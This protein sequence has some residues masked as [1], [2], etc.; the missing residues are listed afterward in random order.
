MNKIALH[1]RLEKIAD[2]EAFREATKEELRVL[3]AAISL[4]KRETSYEDL[5]LLAGVSSARAKSA[6]TLFLESGILSCADEYADV[7]DEFD[8]PE[9]LD[10]SVSAAKEIRD[11]S[12]AELID[13]CAA[14]IGVPALPTDDVK[15]ITS[16]YSDEGIPCENI[17]IITA[18]LASKV[19]EG[20]RLTSRRIVSE[21]VKLRERGI[22]T[23]EA[24][25]A[26]Y[27]EKDKE[28]KDE[29][30][31]RRVL[32]LSGKI[33]D[34][35]RE[36]IDKWA[37]VYEYSTAIVAFAFEITRLNTTKTSILYM[38]KLLTAWHG[39]G[40]KTLEDCKREHEANGEKLKEKF[41]IPEKK[42]GSGTPRVAQTPKYSDFNSED[43]LLKAL[44]RSYGTDKKD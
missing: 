22:D 28:I 38:D 14:I 18:Y 33:S 31:Y 23:C 43:A 29:W 26:Y 36:Y 27:Y 30:E 34:A 21:A 8:T 17:L 11:S 2:N 16:L 42:N 1:A 19:K 37:H 39:A 6:V 10:T 40:C 3:V 5:A 41:A 13:E 32:G 15:A 7:S 9:K 24:I 35:E 25:N 20:K 12:L 44:E 4:G